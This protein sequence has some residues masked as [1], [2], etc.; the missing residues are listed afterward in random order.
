MQPSQTERPVK[1]NPRPRAAGE[2]AI[3]AGPHET[4]FGYPK[5]FLTNRFVYVVISPRAGGLSIGVNMNP[6]KACD[7]DCLYCEV[8]RSKP[9]AEPQLDIKTM[10]AELRATVQTVGSG[11]LQALPRY[12]ILPA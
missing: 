2:P 1:Q 12:R 7:Y 6:D 5:D 3:P 8:D 10:A 4:A 9:G 11:G